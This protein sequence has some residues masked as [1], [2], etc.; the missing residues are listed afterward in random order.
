MAAQQ[1]RGGVAMAAIATAGIAATEPKFPHTAF[2]VLSFP[3]LKSMN[4][5]DLLSIHISFSLSTSLSYNSSSS[6]I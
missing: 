3:S 1:A 5:V 6:N 4:R 2:L